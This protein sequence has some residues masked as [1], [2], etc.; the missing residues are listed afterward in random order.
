MVPPIVS[1]R[2]VG[3]GEAGMRGG[4]TAGVFLAGWMLAGLTWADTPL[5]ERVHLATTDWCPYVCENDLAHPGVVYEHMEQ[6][7]AELG[8]VL[9]IN[10]YPWSRAIQ[11]A[12]EGQ[13][14]GLLTATPEEAPSLAFTREP[15]LHFQSCFFAGKSRSWHYSG[16]SSLEAVRLGVIKDYAYGSPIDEFVLARE[17]ATHLVIM[18]GGHEIPRMYHMVRLGRLDAFLEDRFTLRWSLLRAEL[19]PAALEEAGCLEPAPFFFALN[20]Q[21]P[22]GEALLERLNQLFTSD[23]NQVRR[24]RIIQRYGLN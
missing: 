19:D 22:W 6:T 13:V 2:G 15:T 24:D 21:L 16:L 12:R 10:F 17:N 4:H 3:V 9:E 1:E 5:P 11:L 23:A 18:A 7:F 20:P 14:D 8:V